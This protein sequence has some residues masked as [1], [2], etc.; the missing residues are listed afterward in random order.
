MMA[1]ENRIRARGR[2]FFIGIENWLKWG[3]GPG[4]DVLRNA[5]PT[6]GG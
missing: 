2:N 6:L 1:A 4:D 3:I 5:T